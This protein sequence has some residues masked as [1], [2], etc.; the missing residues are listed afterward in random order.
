LFSLHWRR[1]FF[2]DGGRQMI[3]FVEPT[4][5]L[6]FYDVFIMGALLLLI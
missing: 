2:N 3:L 1:P 5:A 4:T 6:F